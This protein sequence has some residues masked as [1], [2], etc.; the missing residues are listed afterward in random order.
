MIKSIY[1]IK[2]IFS[3]L[4]QKKVLYFIIYNKVLQK[5]IGININTYKKT[6]GK[7]RII[8]KDGKVAVE[9]EGI[10]VILKE[11]EDSIIKHNR[12]GTV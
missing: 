5:R 12:N 1:R 9:S 3:F 4:C 7:Y 2:Q 10:F 11:S 6:S 8:E